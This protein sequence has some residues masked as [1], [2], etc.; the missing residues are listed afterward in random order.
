MP[1]LADAIQDDGCGS[2][3][4]LNHCREQSEHCQGCW[5]VDAK[6]AK[7]KMLRRD[8]VSELQVPVHDRV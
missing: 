7:L 3:D 1:I 4:I 2:P 5:V 6:G 8:Q